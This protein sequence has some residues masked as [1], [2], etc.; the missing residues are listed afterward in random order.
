MGAETVDTRGIEQLARGFP[1][2]QAASLREPARRRRVS[3]DTMDRLQNPDGTACV[4][5]L[6]RL[7]GKIVLVKSARDH[8]NPPT[9]M[10]GTIEVRDNPG[11]TPHVGLAVDFPQ[12]FT[13]PA[14][15]RTIPLD[16]AA[17]MRLLD[18]EHNGTYAFTIEGDLD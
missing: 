17:I 13:M 2:L 15:R 14:H 5:D 18:S 8:R 12:M 9:A 1:R 7:H 6:H 3:G 4:D 10:R 11:A 16:H